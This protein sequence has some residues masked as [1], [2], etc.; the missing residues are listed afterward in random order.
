MGTSNQSVTFMATVFLG[1]ICGFASTPVLAADEATN[2]ATVLEEIIV[3][4]HKREENLQTF[5]GSITALDGDIFSAQLISNMQDIRNIVPNLY[6]D[7]DLGGQGTVKIFVRGIG[8]DN[9]AVSFDSPVGIYVDGVYHAR[10]F[11]SLTDLYDI[12]GSS[13]CAGHKARS[14]VA[15]TL[16]A[17]YRSSQRPRSWMYLKPAPHWATARKASSTPMRF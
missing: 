5:A 14:M 7:E 8:I 4:A 17:L 12:N 6:L 11:G 13:F 1:L 16:P 2:E 9:P 15:I 3:T 10:A